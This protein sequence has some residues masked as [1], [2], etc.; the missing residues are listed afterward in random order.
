VA[1]AERGG[2]SLRRIRRIL[3]QLDD[4]PAALLH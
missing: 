1:A 2:M 4:E 3:E